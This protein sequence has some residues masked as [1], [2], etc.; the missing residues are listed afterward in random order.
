MEKNEKYKNLDFCLAKDTRDCVLV[1]KN[2]NGFRRLW[3]QQ[4]TT[5]DLVRLETAEAILSKYSSPT[6]LFQVWIRVYDDFFC[7]HLKIA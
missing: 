4:L 6:Q 2:G 1:D 3:Q 5:F 7:V